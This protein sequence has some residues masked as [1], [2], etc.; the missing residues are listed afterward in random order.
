MR[1]WKLAAVLAAVSLLLAVALAAAQEPVRDFSQL[2]TRLKPGD[3]VWVTD[4]QGREVKGT[5]RTLSPDTLTLSSDDARSYAA[6]DVLQLRQRRPDPLWNGAIIGLAVGG[7]LGIA[8]G[9]FSGSWRWSDAAVG[10][11]M[12]GSIGAGIGLG[13]DAMIPGR[14]QVV[15]RAPGF[16]AASP[17]RLF[18]APILTPR[19]K[20]LA[21]SFAF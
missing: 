5:I 8:M 7:G 1:S 17:A 13:I 12:F 19:A 21:V 15:Y 16:A 2:N 6:A 9:D 18:A 14:R 20:G 3:T 4:A 10:A 11:L